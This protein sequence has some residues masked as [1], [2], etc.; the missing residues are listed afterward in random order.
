MLRPALA[1]LALLPA[2]GAPGPAALPERGELILL[3]TRQFDR[4]ASAWNRGDLDAFVSDYANDSTTTFIVGGHLRRGFTFIRQLYAPRFL[5]G[6]ARDSLSFEEFD[7]RPLNPSLALVT[8][9]WRLSRGR[10]TTSSG[11]FTLLMERHPDGW[12][13]LHD[14]SSSDSQ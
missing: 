5:P 8:A 4:A 9:R 14:H 13:I 12:K 11:P 1:F 2:C 10:T 3:I 6:A 7:V